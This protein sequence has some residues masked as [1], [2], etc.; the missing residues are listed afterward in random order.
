MN[1]AGSS[2]TSDILFHIEGGLMRLLYRCQPSLILPLLVCTGSDNMWHRCTLKWRQFDLQGTFLNPH[3][4]CHSYLGL[5]WYSMQGSRIQNAQKCSPSEVSYSVA[6]EWVQLFHADLLIVDVT[7]PML[8]PG[9]GITSPCQT[10]KKGLTRPRFCSG[11]AL[12]LCLS[13]GIPVSS[14]EMKRH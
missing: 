1:T 9:L 4:F 12:A 8:V 5:K 7:S 2:L 6:D 10:L 3:G 11:R 14:V 13:Q